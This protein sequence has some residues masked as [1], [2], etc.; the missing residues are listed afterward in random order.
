MCF[1]VSMAWGGDS[2]LHRTVF[3][4]VDP[5]IHL[6]T[7]LDRSRLEKRIRKYVTKGV[8]GLEFYR[9][10][11]TE[12]VN[13]YADNVFASLWQHF[14]EKVWFTQADFLFSSGD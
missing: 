5:I 4:A 11:F 3:E 12:L 1:P 2:L 6:E 13:D 8:N 9:K 10:S 14:G 7:E